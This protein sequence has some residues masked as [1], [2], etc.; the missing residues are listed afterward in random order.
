MRDKYSLL[1]SGFGSPFPGRKVL[2]AMVISLVLACLGSFVTAQDQPT[3]L[4]PGTTMVCDSEQSIGFRWVKGEWKSTD[5]IAASYI[6]VKKPSKMVAAKAGACWGMSAIA[7]VDR[8]SGEV[9]LPA[10]YS[11]R[12]HEGASK[13]AREQVCSEHMVRE[14]GRWVV[15]GIACETFKFKPNG[16]FH[17]T[18][19]HDNLVDRPE[20]DHK[21]SL[22]MTVGHCHTVR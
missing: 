12:H 20:N 22:S 17:R 14:N 10:C 11:I 5:F 1:I 18:S 7:Q 9:F 21:D 19:L 13:D 2:Q 4:L 3:G 6:I 15:A 8:L 16:W